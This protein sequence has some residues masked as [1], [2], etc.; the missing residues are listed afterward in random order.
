MITKRNVIVNI[1]SGLLAKTAVAGESSYSSDDYNR[2]ALD[3]LYPQMPSAIPGW[4]TDA[5]A[6]KLAAKVASLRQKYATQEPQELRAALTHWLDYYDM[7]ASESKRKV[8]EVDRSIEKYTAEQK[9]KQDRANAL[10][11][12]LTSSGINIP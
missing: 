6:D 8:G 9:V 11:D 5:E 3:M 10:K 7:R 12:S 1:L 4:A 2:L